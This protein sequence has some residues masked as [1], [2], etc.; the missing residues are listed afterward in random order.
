MQHPITQSNFSINGTVVNRFSNFCES[1]RIALASPLLPIP[2]CA[3]S[4]P[5]WAAPL[6]PAAARLAG[7]GCVRPPPLFTPHGR[8]AAPLRPLLC[9]TPAAPQMGAAGLPHCRPRGRLPRAARH[10]SGL[11]CLPAPPVPA[12]TERE[13]QLTPEFAAPVRLDAATPGNPQRRTFL[14][15][16]ARHAAAYPPAGPRDDR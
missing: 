10:R 4:H 1:L 15:A 6:L 8:H 2:T 12:I 11:L 7:R 3:A 5:C 9:R 14:A 16:Q 13:A